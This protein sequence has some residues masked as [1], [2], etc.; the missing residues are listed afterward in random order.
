MRQWISLSM[1]AEKAHYVIVY[2]RLYLA[3]E[4]WSSSL[5]QMVNMSKTLALARF[6]LLSSIRPNT[7]CVSLRKTLWIPSLCGL[8]IISY[9]WYCSL[10]HRLI[11]IS[12]N[13]SIYGIVVLRGWAYINILDSKWCIKLNFD[14]VVGSSAMLM[15][16]VLLPLPAALTIDSQA[17]KP[18]LRSRL[19]LTW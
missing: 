6:V 15:N 14:F 8:L 18:V 5:L 11:N 19:M 1:S 13:I 3:A 10:T 17:I 2:C 9:Y 16:A 4:V 7:E 12:F